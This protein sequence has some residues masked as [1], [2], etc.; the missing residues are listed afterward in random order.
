LYV[1]DIKLPN[2]ANTL[3]N[4]YENKGSYWLDK[5]LKKIDWYLRK[6][7]NIH[8]IIKFIEVK[9]IIRTSLKIYFIR[10]LSQL[11]T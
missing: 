11:S 9:T 1:H 4:N 6:K 2:A 8:K 10:G 5:S 3:K 7:K